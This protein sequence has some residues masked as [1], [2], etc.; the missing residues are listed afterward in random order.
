MGAGELSHGPQ[1]SLVASTLAAELGINPKLIDQMPYFP[2]ADVL[3]PRKAIC[4]YWCVRTGK[5]YLPNPE[6]R[7]NDYIEQFIT[8]RVANMGAQAYFNQ[9]KQA[10]TDKV[11]ELIALRTLA[12]TYQYGK[13]KM[14]YL[15][16]F[17]RSEIC[18]FLHFPQDIS[19]NDV[20]TK[21]EDASRTA[22]DEE[23]MLG[24]IGYLVSWRSLA[25]KGYDPKII[26]DDK[27][28]ILTN[29]PQDNRGLPAD[30]SILK[31]WGRD[32]TEGEVVEGPISGIDF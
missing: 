5:A 13:N 19:C 1:H 4:I 11:F 28:E 29:R 14:D 7:C 25:G 18:D 16:E 9:L 22:S 10:I 26:N 31:E 6:A 27:I 8:E 12:A 15:P 21:L 32:D 24:R 3:Y 23:Q 20:I 2:Y 30:R 17:R